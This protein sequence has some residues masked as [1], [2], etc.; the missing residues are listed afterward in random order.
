MTVGTDTVCRRQTRPKRNAWTVADAG[1]LLG[2]FRF[3]FSLVQED[4]PRWQCTDRNT[5]RQYAFAIR[6][7]VRG[8]QTPRKMRI[9]YRVELIRCVEAP[10]ESA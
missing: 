1:I 10:V 5:I 6:L 4:R 9:A 2:I 8:S 7:T 3:S